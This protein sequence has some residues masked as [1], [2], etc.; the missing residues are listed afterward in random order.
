MTLSRLIFLVVSLS[1]LVTPNSFADND[2]PYVPAEDENTDQDP[3]NLNRYTLVEYF[4]AD[5]LEEGGVK[6]GLDIDYAP[7]DRFM[8]GT[9]L[10]AL[11]VG[12]PN[13]QMKHQVWEKG[14]HKIAIGL[15]GTYA[16]KNTILWGRYAD[17]FERLDIQMI[18]PSVSWTNQLSSRLNLHTYWSIGI[19]KAEATLSEKGRRSL[20][21]SKHPGGDWATKKKRDEDPDSEPDQENQEDINQESR[22][23]SFSHRTIQVQTLAGILSDLFQITGEY[24]RE[25]GKKIL[26][27]SRVETTTLEDLKSNGFRFTVAQQWIFSRFQFRLGVG[28]Q[29]QVISGVDLDGEKIDQTGVFPAS[30]IDFYMRF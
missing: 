9:D 27:T 25:E 4:T 22:N 16:N 6:L 14:T 13:I 15:F 26:L 8:L 11:V 12:A 30:D 10:L 3:L 18:R 28:L 20:W 19:G 17:H 21:E 23:D 29:Y 24:K 1:I 2:A 5:T 7:I